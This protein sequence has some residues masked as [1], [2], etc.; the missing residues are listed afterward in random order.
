MIDT[1]GNEIKVGDIICFSGT[2]NC[3][4]GMISGIV[5]N[6]QKEKIKFNR[7]DVK[8]ID[9][10]TIIKVVNRSKEAGKF[11]K[12]TAY[13]AFIRSWLEGKFAGEES[14]VAKWIHQGII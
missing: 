2:G 11:V 5:T 12:V 3:E 1:L 7:L 4:Y 9:G 13:S 14:R 8:Y 6:V 10:K